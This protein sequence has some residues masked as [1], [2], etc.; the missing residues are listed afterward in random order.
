MAALFGTNVNMLS[1]LIGLTL[2]AVSVQSTYYAYTYDNG[3]DENCC[4]VRLKDDFCLATP[5]TRS[6]LQLNKQCHSL[7]AQGKNKK[8]LDKIVQRLDVDA[9]HKIAGQILVQLKAPLNGDIVADD[10][11]CLSPANNHIDLEKCH[12]EWSAPKAKKSSNESAT[13][14]DS[15]QEPS[16]SET[17]RQLK[18]Q[19]PVEIRQ[20][21]GLSIRQT[22][23]LNLTAIKLTTRRQRD[24]WT[25]YRSQ[26]KKICCDPKK[27]QKTCIELNAAQEKCLDE[28]VFSTDDKQPV[29]S[30]STKLFCEN[31]KQVNKHV[32]N[33]RRSEICFQANNH[34]TTERKF[35][36]LVS[37]SDGKKNRAVLEFIANNTRLREEFESDC[38]DKET[39]TDVL[40][41]M[42][43]RQAQLVTDEG[44]P[45]AA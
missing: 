22:Y 8:Y 37:L 5:L 33:Y 20:G 10:L 12:L 38:H 18:V 30:K 1:V 24:C 26:T 7:D 42:E 16:D 45:P 14:T 34:I 23:Q 40:A 28:L 2:V 3:A 31:G 35:T 41:S 9:S 27:H 21:R 4:V 39:L 11:L 15:E 44:Q 43:R 6:L 32:G 29:Y 13:T 17:T 25:W 19:Q 36:D